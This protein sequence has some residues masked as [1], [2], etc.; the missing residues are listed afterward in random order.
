[1]TDLI[2]I[3]NIKKLNNQNYSTWQTC[4]ES[5]LQ[6]QDLWDVVNGNETTPPEDIGALKKWCIKAGKAMF[7]IN[8]TIEEEM[9]EHIRHA[10]TLRV[11]WD[12]FVSRFSKKN[13]MRLQLLENELMSVTQR[14]MTIN[15]YFTKVKSLCLEISELDATSKIGDDRMRRIIIHGL[16]PEYRSF[17]TAIQ[18]WPVQPSLE[19]LENLLANQ[20]TLVKQVAGVSI[21][22]EEEALFSNKRQSRS[23]GQH[24][25]KDN[26]SK[27]WQ[28]KS[29][30]AGG[31]DQSQGNGKR[32]G[33][34][35][36]FECYNCGK[37]GHFARDCHFKKKAVEGNTATSSNQKSSE[38]EWDM[39]ASF[40]VVEGSRDA[41]TTS[42]VVVK[43]E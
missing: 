42:V 9:L 19:D 38:D 26:N 28:N 24:V 6:G 8:T 2:T 39:E 30:Q 4:M 1:M 5:Y 15:Q 16:K 3:G 36:N 13:D 7:V 33:K 43:N 34:P 12:V 41:V 25:D 10:T 17:I 27:K 22:N 14:D 37:K 29:N 35:H 21:K 32:Q 20:E 31:A 23:R 40:A 18:G 11:A